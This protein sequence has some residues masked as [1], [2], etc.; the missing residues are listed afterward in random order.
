[1]ENIIDRISIDIATGDP[2]TP[3]ATPYKYCTLIDNKELDM[4]SYNYETILAEKIQTILSRS[5]LNSRSKDFYDVYIIYKLKWDEIDVLLLK[6]AFAKTCEYRNTLFDKYET[7]KILSLLH[8][9]KDMN[10]RWKIY[11]KK[12]AFANDLTYEDIIEV[13]KKA[14]VYLYVE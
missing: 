12:N 4:K 9:N 2:I 13:I 10:S 14:I 8:D 5:I 6:E 11:S 7:E 3:G 1:M